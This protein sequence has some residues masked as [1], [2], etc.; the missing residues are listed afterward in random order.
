MNNI[1]TYIYKRGNGHK[2]YIIIIKRELY[3]FFSLVQVI[4]LQTDALAII[5]IIADTIEI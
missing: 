3:I 5:N 4:G 2:I 1:Y